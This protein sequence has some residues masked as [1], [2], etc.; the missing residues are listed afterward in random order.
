MTVT[1]D[2]KDGARIYK[3]TRPIEDSAN[4]LATKY[5]AGFDIN[6]EKLGTEDA[7]FHGTMDY[8]AGSELKKDDCTGNYAAKRD[9]PVNVIEAGQQP[10]SPEV[11]TFLAITPLDGRDNLV[12]SWADSIFS[13]VWS[14]KHPQHISKR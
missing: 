7:W 13:D 2:T 4:S 1:A 9:T 8:Y 12:Q 5:R 3:L 6:L 10:L 11:T 14:Y